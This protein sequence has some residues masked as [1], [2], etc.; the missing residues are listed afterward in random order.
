MT[1]WT[2]TEVTYSSE[3]DPQD[4]WD[5]GD[6]QGTLRSCGVTVGAPTHVAYDESMAF[7]E[8]DIGFM[9]Q[10]GDTVFMV[11]EQYGDG[12]TFGTRRGLCR[13]QHLFK[14]YAEA[15]AWTK[16]EEAKRC[17]DTD[18]FGGHEEWLIQET[19]VS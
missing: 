15:E 17:E 4:E 18:Y 7:N 16:T 6:E 3:P 14:T 2:D 12:S 19:V 9:P 11:I 13:P 5:A 10:K 1:A 8:A